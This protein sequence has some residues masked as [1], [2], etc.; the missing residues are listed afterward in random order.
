MNKVYQDTVQMAVILKKQVAEIRELKKKEFK[1]DRV[2]KEV[3]KRFCRGG[4]LC[5]AC[6]VDENVYRIGKL[7]VLWGQGTVFLE[8]NLALVIALIILEQ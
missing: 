2:M 7:L 3:A 4:R 8:G 6:G 1:R 5:R